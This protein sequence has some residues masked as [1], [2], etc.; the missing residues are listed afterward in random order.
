MISELNERSRQ[1]FR[2]L[3][4]AYLAE[5]VP[6][7][8]KSIAAQLPAVLSSAT[9]RNVMKDLEDMGLLYSPHTSAG[10]M[11]T[12]AGLRMFVDALLE[13][14]NVTEA[15]AREIEA[16]AMA[17]GAKPEEVLSDATS[18]LSGLARC[19]G[20]VLSPK[21]EIVLKHIEFVLIS[22][23][24]ALT[25]IV[26][27]DGQVENRL[28]TVPMGMTAGALQQAANYL[29][30]R[31]LGRTLEEARRQVQTELEAKRTELDTLSASAVEAGLAI[32]G[33]GHN[34]PEGPSLIVRGHANLLED[35]RALEDLER[36]RR[37][38]DD[39]ESKSDLIHLLELARNAEGVRIFIG[40][41]NKLFS[42]S[43]SSLVLSPYRNKGGQI[44]GVIGVIG[45]T[46]L[47]YARIIPM[48]DYT[49][50]VIGQ[51]LS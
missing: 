36:I 42:L 22:P 37:L 50:R 48:V 3:V 30:A 19:A 23:G 40:S 2:A 1:I 31:L 5:G 21:Q 27:Q 43:G 15:E 4:E 38:F 35:V 13:V 17:R 44:V 51:L 41:E 26:G 33:G 14:G 28:I 47:N 11:P 45:P 32:W 39:L 25:I 8:S 9:I 29:N 16:M 12:Q 46:R 10:R 7:G 6:V 18:R 24:Q 34:N 20:L 49:A